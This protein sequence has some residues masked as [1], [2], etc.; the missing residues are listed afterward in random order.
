MAT[1]IIK[2][3]TVVISKC[4]AKLTRSDSTDLLRDLFIMIREPPDI[5]LFVP[6]SFSTG[7]DPVPVMVFFQ[8]R[9]A[10]EHK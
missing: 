1:Q 7:L 9:G 3:Y 6:S 4:N 2:L 10:Y 5:F 8:H